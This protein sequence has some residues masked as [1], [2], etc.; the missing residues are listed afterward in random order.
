MSVTARNAG[1]HD[2][3][4]NTLSV[5]L[6]EDSDVDT[7]DSNIANINIADIEGGG[8]FSDEVQLTAPLIAKTYYYAVRISSETTEYSTNNNWSSTMRLNVGSPDIE[9]SVPTADI[10][11]PYQGVLLICRLP[12][13][14]QGKDKLI[15]LALFYSPLEI[16]M[17]PPR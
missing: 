6:S 13:P 9:L 3:S 17:L 1:I 2:A 7:S 4:S 14:I 15:M 10:T 8:I 12:P 5:Y 16:L 11:T